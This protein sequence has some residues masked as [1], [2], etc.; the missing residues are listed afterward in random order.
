M[1]VQYKITHSSQLSKKV[2]IA[3]ISGNFPERITAVEMHTKT[4][5]RIAFGNFN[6][7]QINFDFLKLF[8]N[9]SLIINNMNSFTHKISKLV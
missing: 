2:N 1:V 4:N 6:I 8:T 3:R 5:H 9:Y 7:Y